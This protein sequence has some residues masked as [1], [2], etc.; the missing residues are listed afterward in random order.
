ML[1]AYLAHSSVDKD[2]VRTV[3]KR[4]GRGDI[5][6]D[7]M[8][9]P[10]GFDFRDTIR[11]SLDK[12]SVFVFFASKTSLE[13][14][15]VKFEINEA[16]WRLSIQKMSG[17]LTIIIDDQTKPEDLPKWMQRNLVVRVL[18]PQLAVH[19]IKN[20]LVQL[21]TPGIQPIFVGR[22]SDL[23]RISSK[24]IPEIEEKAPRI[25][26]I[27]GL[28]GIGRRTFARRALR[29]Y[30]SMDTGPIFVLEDN[31]SMDSLYLHLLNE[32]TDLSKRDH[33]ASLITKFRQLDPSGKG[34]ETARLLAVINQNKQIPIII[35]TGP[36]GILL[37]EFSGWYRDEW[38]QLFKA[39]ELFQDTYVLLIQ[40]RMPDYREASKIRTDM[41]K[42]V[43]ERLAPLSIDAIKLI[44][45]ESVHR[46]EVSIKSTQIDELAP[47]IGGYPPAAK[48]SLGYIQTYGIDALLAE[49]A[50]LT[51]FLAHQFDKIL[52]KLVS[53]DEEKYILRLLASHTSLPLESFSALM[54]ISSE[55]TVQ[56]IRHL[57]D[58][59]LIIHI[60]NEYSISSPIASSVRRNFGPLVK[61]DYAKIAK[62]LKIVFWADRENLPSLS[63][64]DLTIHALAYSDVGELTDFRDL[65]LPSQLLKVAWQKY[66]QADWIGA[67]DIADRTLTLEPT[68]HRAKVVKFK[69]LVRLGK[70]PEA[71]IILGEIDSNN[72]LDRFY[73]RGFM[74]WKQGHH[75]SAV[76]LFR[77]GLNAGDHSLALERDLAYCLMVLGDLD[78]AKVHSDITIGRVR[79]FYTLDLAAQIAIYS[80]RI[81]DAQAHIKAIEPI[82]EKGYYHRLATLEKSQ[83]HLELAL[84]HSETACNCENPTFE[85]LIQKTEILI[86]LNRHEAETIINRLNPSF[87]IKSDM[88]KSFCQ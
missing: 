74:H 36:R 39:L 53:G 55:I 82:D 73:L 25:I 41:P 65:V 70:W 60:D 21:S 62:I 51:D 48:F 80:N 58:I 7:E 31:D 22:E 79:N 46:G 19:T 61:S 4:L 38:Q 10:P 68:N 83:G 24:L 71:D 6:F 81:P 11:K 54:G 15:W 78:R 26:V 23:L 29:D 67:I 72:S 50:A 47:Y 52:G 3:A 28:H 40:P 69:A 63:I 77:Q 9:F 44:F 57:V 84:V 34:K 85:A 32:T 42:F 2:F 87:S 37:D 35:D 13:S 20:Y 86:D 18:Y 8:S 76:K 17:S 88:K 45:R 56:F 49:K 14:T 30:L 43:T 1:K 5:I 27:T 59:N 66:N 16:D 64:V 12:S 75:D 33:F